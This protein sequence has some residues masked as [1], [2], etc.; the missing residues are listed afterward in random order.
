MKR[1]F[2]II[3]LSGIFFTSCKKDETQE[4]PPTQTTADYIQ[5]KLGNYW[6]YERYNIDT[7]GNETTSGLS[8]SLVITS[9]TLI[10]GYTYFKKLDVRQN[11]ASYL[12]DSSGYLVDH[13][14]NILF[15]NDDFNNILRLDTI[16]PGLAVI[17]Y[18]MAEGDTMISIPLGNYQCLDFKGKVTPLQSNYPHGIQYTYYFWADGLGMIK[19]NSYYFSNPLLRTGQKLIAFGNIED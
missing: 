7:L 17:E 12:R 4:N 15:S 8:D 9:D 1:V 6:V 18:E 2:L 10:R 14:G 13:L 11:H 19:S 5:L 16:G 3:V